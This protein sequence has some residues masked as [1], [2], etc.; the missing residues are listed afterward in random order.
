MANITNVVESLIER[1]KSETIKWTTLDFLKS[2]LREQNKSLR[3]IKCFQ[4][5]TEFLSKDKKFIFD[6]KESYFCVTDIHLYILSKSLYG[7]EY[8]LDKINLQSEKGWKKMEFSTP[9]LL[10][11][12][13]AVALTSADSKDNCEQ[14]LIKLNGKLS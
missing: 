6:C 1:V 14:D 10:R 8:R 12:K 2:H 4:L 13:N 3:D 11:L 5:Y 7:L 9:V